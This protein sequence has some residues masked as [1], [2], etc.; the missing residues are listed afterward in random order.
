M[1]I[2]CFTEVKYGAWVA[3]LILAYRRFLKQVFKKWCLISSPGIILFYLAQMRAA[4]L[5]RALAG[6]DRRNVSFS[7]DSNG[8]SVW[9]MAL[10]GK[11][12][13]PLTLLRRAQD[14]PFDWA[15]DRPFDW[16]QDRPF[17]W[18]QDRPF[19]W[20]QDRPFD[21]AQDRLRSFETARHPRASSE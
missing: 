13:P 6:C 14:R 1:S 4:P 9:V 19:D 5:V 15:Q 12:A 17:D 10:L 2:P 8:R 21:W 11:G 18:A 20:A 16:A 7:F 3:S